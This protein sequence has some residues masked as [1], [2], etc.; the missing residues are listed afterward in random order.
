MNSE[1]RRILSCQERYMSFEWMWWWGRLHPVVECG[2]RWVVVGEMTDGGATSLHTHLP[3]NSQS[4][5]AFRFPFITQHLHN[6]NYKWMWGLDYQWILLW[7]NVFVEHR[8]NSNV[9]MGFSFN[10]TSSYRAVWQRLMNILS[11]SYS[12]THIR[13]PMILQ[14]NGGK[15][16]LSSVSVLFLGLLVQERILY[17]PYYYHLIP[18]VYSA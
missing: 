11:K 9:I 1:S 8:Q 3:S 14:K 17:R 2:W 18:S 10:T 12:S 13:I 6:S 16:L 15:D 7:I 5:Y 4:F